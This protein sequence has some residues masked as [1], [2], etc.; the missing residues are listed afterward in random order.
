MQGLGWIQC[1]VGVG[2][3]V[4]CSALEATNSGKNKSAT[5]MIKG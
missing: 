5:L 3:E 4:F 1:G 2:E